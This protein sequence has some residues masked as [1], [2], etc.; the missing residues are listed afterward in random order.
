MRCW[1]FATRVP[2]R[3]ATN[4]LQRLW[5]R[6]RAALEGRVRLLGQGSSPSGA[7]ALTFKSVEAKNQWKDQD[8]VASVLV[9]GNAV[10]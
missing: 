8:K 6:Y 3:K 4:Q 7:I 10:H 9:K 5:R 1:P 2:A